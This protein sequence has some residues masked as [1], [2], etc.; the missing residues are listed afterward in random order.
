V[1]GY[2]SYIKT[3]S[4]VTHLITEGYWWSVLYASVALFVLIMICF[5][6]ASA[7]AKANL[8]IFILIGVALLSGLGNCS[9]DDAMISHPRDRPT[10]FH[11]KGS[12]LF[13]KEGVIEGFTGPSLTT[14]RDNLYPQFTP[15]RDKYGL[16]ER[17]T[18][19]EFCS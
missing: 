9:N 4:R 14:L 10:N 8:F 3:D 1:E 18:T 15:V 12:L 13:Q 6:G 17:D 19:E 5:L 2:L 7:F 11:T 16:Y